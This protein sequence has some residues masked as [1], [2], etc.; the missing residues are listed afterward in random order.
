MNGLS[1]LAF[2]AVL[3]PGAFGLSACVHEMGP[4][5]KAGANIDEAFGLKPGPGKVDGPAEN[6]GERIDNATDNNKDDLD[7][8]NR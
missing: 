6:L 2:A 3:L 8:P 1:K 7:S 5:E 4:A